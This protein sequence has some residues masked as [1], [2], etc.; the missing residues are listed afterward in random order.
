MAEY[1]EIGYK[2]DILTCAPQKFPNL[3]LI[4]Q[5]GYWLKR[6]KDRSD[7]RIQSDLSLTERENS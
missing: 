3:N 1:R 5:I 6:E 7:R 4:E 2:L